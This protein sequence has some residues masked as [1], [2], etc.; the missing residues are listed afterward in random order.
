MTLQENLTELSSYNIDFRYYG[1]WILV[2][3]EY[4]KGWQII[5]PTNPLIE[6][7]AKDGKYYYS[8]PMNEVNIDEVFDLIKETIEHNKDLQKKVELFQEKIE[9][10]QK[11]FAEQ[12]YDTLL[13]LSFKYKKYKKKRMKEDNNDDNSVFHENKVLCKK[14]DDVKEDDGVRFVDTM[15][16]DEDEIIEN[17]FVEPLE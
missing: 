10:L 2:G 17:K 13:T 1:N 8:A 3:V 5:E 4:D 15:N 14:Q 12:D 6:H 7:M 16:E 9:E 11:I